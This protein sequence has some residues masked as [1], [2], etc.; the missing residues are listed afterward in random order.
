MKPWESRAVIRATA[1]VVLA[2][3]LAAC[4]TTSFSES[5]RPVGAGPEGVVS[6]SVFDSARDIRRGALTERHVHSELYRREAASDRP[7]CAS[8]QPDWQRTGLEPGTYRLRVVSGGAE[9]GRGSRTK[10]EVFQVHAFREVRF[11]VVLR[12]G[13]EVAHDAALAIA[14]LVAVSASG[15]VVDLPANR[16]VG[17]GWVP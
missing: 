5:L 2:V 15:G 14:L 12:H 4:L 7:V 6:V 16:D 10:D 8:D 1:A 9:D 11:E 13:A 17:V 3:P